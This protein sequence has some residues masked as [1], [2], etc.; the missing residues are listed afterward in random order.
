MDGSGT[1]AASL[2]QPFARDS[3]VDPATGES[4]DNWDMTYSVT[5]VD[6]TPAVKMSLDPSWLSGSDIAFPVTVDPTMT[7]STAGQ[8]LT[9]Y[10]YHPNELRADIVPNVIYRPRQHDWV[11]IG[12]TSCSSCTHSVPTPGVC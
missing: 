5:D 4:H 7:V 9:T 10:V 1:V 8:T 11:N 12:P 6:G 3:H 2:P